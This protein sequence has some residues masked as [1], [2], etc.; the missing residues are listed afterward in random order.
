VNFPSKGVLLDILKGIVA[1]VTLFL[2]YAS[3]PLFGL[4][5]GVLA[6]LP[7]V[8]YSLRLGKI[9]GG[10]IVIVSAALLFILADKVIIVLYLLQIASVSILL[11]FFLERRSSSA[12]IFLTA[13]S[14][15]AIILAASFGYSLASGINLDAEAQKWLSAGISQT[16]S[17]YSK[18]G[19]KDAELQELQQG[20]RQAGSVMVR[21]YPAMLAI[22]QAIIVIV[23]MLA[24]AGFVRRGQLKLTIGE[25][26]DF[27]NSE[28][29]VWFL[30]A[31]GFAMLIESD[32]VG[33]VALNI[34]LT[35]CFA[36]F[37][38]GLAVMS[39]FFTRFAVPAIGRFFFY[40]FLLLQPYLLAGVAILGIFDMW[41]NFRTPRQQNL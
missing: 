32:I 27:R 21:V 18:S 29:L 17:L 13:V 5:G 16:A 30:I 24:V 15:L 14:S 20:L 38:Q 34:L 31:S 28:Y 11:P 12:S 37:F 7:A 10:A 3:L 33:R 36:Y 23:T 35:V 39:H 25:F 22:S 9:A 40:M 1:T 19:L 6:P 41:G 2:A 8:Y 26:K 4:F